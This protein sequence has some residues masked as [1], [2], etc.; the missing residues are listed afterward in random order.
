MRTQQKPVKV[1]KVESMFEVGYITTYSDKTG[2]AIYIT[3]PDGNHEFIKEEPKEKLEI[4][5]YNNQ[6]SLF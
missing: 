3:R 1:F 5:K 6:Q 2:E 4:S